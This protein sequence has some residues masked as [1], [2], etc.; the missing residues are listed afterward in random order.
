MAR[1]TPDVFRAI[2][3]P[4]RRQILKLL[5]RQTLTVNSLVEN[6]RISRPAISRHI[7]ILNASGF[8]SIEDI[9]R[10]RYCKLKQNG[11]ADVQR[12]IRYYDVF[13]RSKLNNLEA[14]LNQEHPK[15]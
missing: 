11:F 10:E 2:S 4:S 1:S 9:G 15:K 13:W 6:F 8:I 7:R 3:D 5:S 14:L 12:W